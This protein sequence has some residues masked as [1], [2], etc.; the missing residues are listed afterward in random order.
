M[1]LSNGREYLAIPGPSVMPD[2][3][4][5][6]MNRAAPN[7]YEGDLIDMVAAMI[8]DLRAVARTRHNAAIYI[9]NGHAA[10]EA[11]LANVIAPGD[12]VLVPATGRFAHGW[13]DMAHGLGVKTDIIDFGRSTPLDPARVEESLRSDT[14]GRIKAVLVTH[15]DTSTSIRN[16]VAGV[17]AAIDAAGHP[18]LLMVDCIASLACDRFEMDAWGVDVMVAGSQKGLMVPPG[19]GFVFFSPKA[20]EARARMPRVS[21]YWD[22]TP[23]ANPEHFYQY[24]GGTAPTH[25]LFGLREA[26]TMLHEEGMEAVWAR[27]AALARAI[28]AACETWGQEGPLTLNLTDRAYRSHAVTSLRIGPPHGTELRQWVSQ[29]AGVTLGIGLGMAEPGDPA[30]HGFFR[31]GHMG[32]VNAHMVLGVLGAIDAGLKAIGVPHGPGALDAA[33]AVIAEAA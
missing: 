2:R 11:A 10:W 27:H 33:T 5:R 28:W 9:G 12:T 8:P 25:H 32:H 7:I 26:L 31:I 24:W 20:A 21:R 30:W 4:L 1:T 3:V 16:D 19:L 6:A 17:R 23:R 22:W 18:A 15:V 13:A 29:K 14:K